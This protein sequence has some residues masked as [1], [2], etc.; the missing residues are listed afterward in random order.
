MTHIAP[1]INIYI[2][3]FCTEMSCTPEEYTH[4]VPS[5]EMFEQ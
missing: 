3:A 4:S 2:Q 5:E 1:K